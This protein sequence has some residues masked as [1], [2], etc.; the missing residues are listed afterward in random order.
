MT[1]WLMKTRNRTILRFKY[2]FLHVF[3]LGIAAGYHVARKARRHRRRRSALNTQNN[4][5]D[6]KIYQNPKNIVACGNKRSR[7]NGGINASFVQKQRYKGPYNPCHH[8]YGD[9]G[10]GNGQRGKKTSFPHPGKK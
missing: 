3:A 4:L 8:R 5:G 7:C 10:D 9:Q 1:A 2:K 6:G